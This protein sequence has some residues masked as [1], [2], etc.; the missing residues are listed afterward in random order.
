MKAAFSEVNKASGVDGREIRM[1]PKADCYLASRTL[2]K[3]TEMM[4]SQ[5]I[6]ALISLQGAANTAALMPLIGSRLSPLS[7]P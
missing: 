4:D 6:F 2:R 5:S 7:H 3:V 1:E